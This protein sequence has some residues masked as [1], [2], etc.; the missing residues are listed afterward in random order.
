VESVA[1]IIPVKDEEVGLQYLLDNYKSSTL[2][3]NSNISFIFVID[4]RTS[5]L[6]KI[7]AKKFSDLIIDQNET[8]G[9]GAAIKQALQVWNNNMTDFVLFMDAD[10]SY[11]F[12]DASK[13]IDE[14]N[15]GA[16]V[17]SGSR[18]LSRK[19]IPE[20]MGHLHNFG[21]RFLSKV[22][23]VR[24]R[25]KLSDLCTGLWGFKSDSIAKLGIRS[26]GFDLEAEIVGKIRRAKINHV[27]IPVNWS[28]RKGGASKLKSFRDGT[29]ILLRI[30]RT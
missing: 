25:R 26:N 23:S 20:G 2:F 3:N 9:K 19:G 17:V 18:F 15:A 16:D 5:D 6:S 10:G 28:A 12:E 21:N 22:S 14:L 13:I 27:E 29:I 8:H 11:S 1:I 7:I 30:L 4:G 24:N